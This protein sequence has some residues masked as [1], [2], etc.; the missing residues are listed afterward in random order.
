VDDLESPS[1]KVTKQAGGHVGV[2]QNLS[3]QKTM[4]D[5]VGSHPTTRLLVD[6]DLE[7]SIRVCLNWTT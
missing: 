6:E 1:P 4:A 7:G 2:N 5:R 3:F